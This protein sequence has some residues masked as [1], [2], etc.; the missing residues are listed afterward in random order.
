MSNDDDHSYPPYGVKRL[1]STSVGKIDSEFG[2]LLAISRK[3]GGQGESSERESPRERMGNIVDHLLFR[4]HA[5]WWVAFSGRV[6]LY[7]L[8]LKPG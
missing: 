8:T 7:G 4:Q 5:R 3:G 2:D 1:V 6:K